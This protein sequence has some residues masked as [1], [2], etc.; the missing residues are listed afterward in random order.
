[1]I[2]YILC[3]CIAFLVFYTRNNRYFYKT[4]FILLSGIILYT[5]I[6]K[7]YLY[8][9]SLPSWH[10]DVSMII[11]IYFGV[12]FMNFIMICMIKIIW[13][14]VLTKTPFDFENSKIKYI[15]IAVYA[16]VYILGNVLINY[17]I[18]LR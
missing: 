11:L 2:N 3:L 10:Y 16:Y 6:S 5:L 18:W 1:M 8:F 9:F 4:F 7:L 13:N 15:Y 17:G 12:Y 14:R